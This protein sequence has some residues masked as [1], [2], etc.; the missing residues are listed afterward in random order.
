MQNL[1]PIKTVD[2]EIFDAITAETTRQQDGIELIP[3][4]NYASSAVVAALSTMLTN[5]YSEGYPGKRYYGGN[6]HIDVIETLACDRVKALFG[7]EHANVQPYSGSPAN[8]AAYFA[9]IEPGSTI[10]G[11]A[12]NDGGHLTHGHKVNF[13]ANYYRAVQYPVD[14]ESG[15]VDYEVI[16]ELAL[17]HRPALI[18]AGYSAYPRQIDFSIFAEIA[19]EVGARLAA[20]IAHIS[21]LVATGL[22]PDPVPYAD[23]VTMTTHKMLRGPRG[24]I[25]L[26]KAEHAKAIDKAVFPGLQGGPHNHTTAA[27]AIC[28]K[29]A[30]EPDYKTY[31]QQVVDNA[32]TLADELMKRDFTVVTGGTDNHLVLLDL[33]NKNV[34]G[35]VASIMLDKAH[36]TVNANTVPGEKRSA[37][38]PSGIRIGT[39]AATTR[40]FGTVEFRRIANLM[41]DVIENVEDEAN[42]NKV[43]GE[44][45]EMCHKLPLWY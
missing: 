5:K 36:I 3:S 34:P 14:P 20:D 2:P 32:Q 45:T 12:L 25:I 7:A 6:E 16:R 30:S 8:L 23:A 17:E 37:F 42:I 28:L 18:W 4:E 31:C 9:L 29:E 40:G 38:D 35:K 44:V 15:L 1:D 33:S 21:G 43:R 24:A 11:M 27:I 13:S 39:P 19:H 10:L 22:H 41:A 26:S